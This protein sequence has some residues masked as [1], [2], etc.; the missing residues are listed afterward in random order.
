MDNKKVFHVPVLLN[1][2]I[3]YFNPSKNQNFIDCTIGFSGH[4]REILKRTSPLGKLLAID[5]D[6]KALEQSKKDLAKYGER[7]EFV[8][9]NYS[10]IEQ[11]IKERNFSLV[12]GILFDFGISSFQLEDEERGFSYQKGGKLDMSFG[13]KAT[14]KSTYNI[15]NFSKKDELID[16]FKKYG[17]LNNFQARRLAEGIVETRKIE[18][19]K[20]AGDLKRLVLKTIPLNYKKESI[21]SKVFQAIRIE[22][23]DELKGIEKGLLGAIK[24]IDSGG[25]IIC[26]SYHSLEDRIVKNIFRNEAKGCICPDEIPVC[27]CNHQAKIK[28]I[29]KKPI[30]PQMEE[31]KINV[32]SRSAKMRVMEKI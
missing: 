12:K 24:A 3:E 25:R 29:N 7:C 27:R 9:D 26:I 18:E 17:E 14:G 28:L 20:T 32:R 6:K 21:L 10:N 1:E 31:I 30:T 23:N 22:T 13:E 15:I 4:S 19:I 16:I 2:V 11:I 5:L 8:E